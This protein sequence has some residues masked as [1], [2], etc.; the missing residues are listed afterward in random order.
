MTFV[1]RRLLAHQFAFLSAFMLASHIPQSFAQ[2]AWPNKPIKII[3]SYAAGGGADTLIR[4][5]APKLGEALGQQIVIENRSGA[6]GLVGGEVAAKSAP[7]GY[8]FLMDAAS[9]GINPSLVAKMPFDTLKDLAPVSLVATVPNVLAVTPNFPAQNIKEL[10]SMVKSSPGKYSFGSAGNGSVQHISGELLKAQAGLFMV[11]IPYRGG[12]PAMAD[13]MAGQIPMYFGSMASATS[14]LKS[15]R[16][17]PIAVTGSKRSAAFPSVP[18]MMESGYPQFEA[19]E[20]NALFAPGGTP[21]AI[22]ER[23][24]REVGKIVQLPE[25]KERFA[26]LSAEPIGSTPAALEQFRR[27]E[28]TQWA[29]VIKRANIRLE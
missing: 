7:D 11:H 26:G 28:L 5:I 29:E 9:H 6:G 25:I 17:R 24:A 27:K 4:V 22:T 1:S 10:I 8:T 2:N 15:G 13:L 21:A 18:T 16:M 19:Y 23:M 3:V 12:A 14:N 20:W